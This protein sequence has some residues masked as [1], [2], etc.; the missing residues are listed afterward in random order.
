VRVTVNLLLHFSSFQRQSSSSVF[1]PFDPP[2]PS[3]RP[4][5]LLGQGK[6]SFRDIWARGTLSTEVSSST[7][8]ELCW[9][10]RL[11]RVP[12]RD[13]K[14]A[15]GELLS[16]LPAW[17]FFFSH[18]VLWFSFPPVCHFHQLKVCADRRRFT[19]LLLLLRRSFL[20]R[21][22]HLNLSIT[23]IAQSH[24][25]FPV[26]PS[27]LPISLFLLDKI[28]KSQTLNFPINIQ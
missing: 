6:R 24:V 21:S 27:F 23:F 28:S 12:K 9:T 1:A 5:F 20:H 22:F 26:S 13:W 10:T 18:S 2:Y 17:R 11:Q 15:A 8:A 16:P 7:K 14:S 25:P 4:L 3:S 19:P